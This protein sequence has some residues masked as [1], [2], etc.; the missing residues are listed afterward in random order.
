MTSGLSQVVQF[1]GGDNLTHDDTGI[2]VDVSVE[3]AVS[4]NPAVILLWDYGKKGNADSIK[5][6]KSALRTT[7]AVKNNKLIPIEGAFTVPGYR[8]ALGAEEVARIL[9]PDLFP[10]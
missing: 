1:G 4:Q 6:L 5:Y 2:E 9:H 7:D 3:K 8:T 10:K